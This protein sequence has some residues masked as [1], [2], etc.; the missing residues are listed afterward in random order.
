MKATTKM[1][2]EA[3]EKGYNIQVIING[4]YYDY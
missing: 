1:M 3:K 2:N 4:E